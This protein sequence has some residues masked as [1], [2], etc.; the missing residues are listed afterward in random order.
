[1]LDLKYKT[2]NGLMWSGIMSFLQQV[3]GL[4]FSIVIARKLNP[5]DFGMVGMLTIFTAVA[6]CLQ[7]GGMVWALTNRKDVS[8]SEY[9]SVFWFNLILSLIIYGI[10]FISAPII[11][12]FY[13]RS[14]LIWLSR[15]IFLGI[16][17]SSLGVVQTAYLFKQIRVKE[18][19]I[20]SI[21]GLIVSGIIGVIFAYCGF[22]YWSIASQ[23]IL[24]IGVT[25]L[26][27]WFLSPFRPSFN[28]DWKFLKLIV[29]EGMK[30]VF[31]NIFAIAGENFFS[32]I[33]GK[34]YT[35]NDV[36]NFTQAAKWNS[37][38]YSSILGMM[39]GVAQPVLVQVRSDNILYL[40]VFRKLLRMATFIV[41]PIM[42]T[43]ALVAPEFIEIVLTAKWSESA[44]IL[45]IL[46]IGGIFCVLN[47]MMSY[48]IMSLGRT[49]LYMNLSVIMALLQVSLSIFASYRGIIALAYTYSGILFISF[50][51][52]Y[53]FVYQTHPYKIMLLIKDLVPIL[54]IGILCM[55]LSYILTNFIQSS[56]IILTARVLIMFLSYITLMHIFNCDSY[57]E[58]RG[59][60]LKK[61]KKMF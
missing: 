31:S 46:C 55:L 3:L 7:D 32:V 27:L 6:T 52:Y 1:M 4:L 43:L 59:F 61:I 12:N 42:L 14:E 51:I 11:A 16:I 58:V 10:L 22:S 5:S 8:H 60:I 25:T 50:F 23:G 33:L 48:F 45:Q 13:S 29:P 40:N 41:T 34:K 20:A 15:Y 53:A 9:S 39:R 44:I 24:N 2:S 19:A 18:R 37:A 28:I 21:T 56:Y 36:G 30:Y 17:L 38:G 47:T 54:G 57:I 26:M 35:V 49:T